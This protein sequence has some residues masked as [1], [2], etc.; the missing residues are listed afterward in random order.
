MLSLPLLLSPGP[1]FFFFVAENRRLVPF[2]RTSLRSSAP[3]VYPDLHVVLTHAC[4]CLP[5]FVFLIRCALPRVSAGAGGAAFSLFFRWR[6]HAAA[7][8][9][10]CRSRSRPRQG[11]RREREVG[12]AVATPGEGCPWSPGIACDAAFWEAGGFCCTYILQ[13]PVEMPKHVGVCVCLFCVL[14]CCCPHCLRV[15][16]KRRLERQRRFC[17]AN[18]AEAKDGHD[19]EAKGMRAMSRLLFWAGTWR[20]VDCVEFC[21]FWAWPGHGALCAV[22]SAGLAGFFRECGGKGRLDEAGWGLFDET[23]AN[24]ASAF[25]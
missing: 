2:F 7:A 21:F 24:L 25:S 5:S 12:G 14:V 15:C 9:P 20:P 13:T 22:F 16:R 23:K 10:T 4:P 18:R 8:P 11:F 17:F 1:F 6:C 19:E 3:P